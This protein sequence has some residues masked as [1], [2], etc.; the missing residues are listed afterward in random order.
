MAI[1]YG[2]RSRLVQGGGLIPVI[3][4][5]GIN[6][7]PDG[8]NQNSSVTL[9]A[10]AVVLGAWVDVRVAEVTGGTKTLDDVANLKF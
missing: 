1:N 6:S 5:A 8:S 3:N 10:K 9:P 7:A 2:S 4:K